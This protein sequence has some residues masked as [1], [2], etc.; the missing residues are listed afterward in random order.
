[1][2]VG[3]LAFLLGICIHVSVVQ[4]GQQTRTELAQSPPCPEEKAQDLFTA[5]RS[6]W[7]WEEKE[8]DSE[9]CYQQTLPSP[10]DTLSSIQF[11]PTSTFRNDVV[12]QSMQAEQSRNDAKLPN[13]RATLVE[14][15][16]AQEVPKCKQSEKGQERAQAKFGERQTSSKRGIWHRDH[17]EGPVG[18]VY[19]TV[20]I[21]QAEAGRDSSRARA[22]Q[23]DG[24]ANSCFREQHHIDDTGGE[25]ETGKFSR[26]RAYGDGT[27][28]KV[29]AGIRPVTDEGERDCRRQSIIAWTH[30]SLEK[31]ESTGANLW[32]QDQGHGSPVATLRQGHT[33]EDKP[34]CQSVSV[35]QSGPD[36]EVQFEDS[37]M[38][39]CEA[40]NQSCIPKSTRSRSAGGTSCGRHPTG[41]A[42]GVPERRDVEERSGS[43]LDLRRRGRGHG[44]AGR[45]CR[46][47]GQGTEETS[48]QSQPITKQ[49][50][51]MSLESEGLM[52]SSASDSE[53]G[54][55]NEQDLNIEDLFQLMQA[56]MS[57][58]WRAPKAWHAKVGPEEGRIEEF[59]PQSQCH[60]GSSS[61]KQFKRK[62]AKAFDFA[63]KSKSR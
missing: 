43:Q 7:S 17:R 18:D 34:P 26:I 37:G 3:R 59:E 46:R 32:I 54:S 6:V 57:A 49:S 45:E 16:D 38:E 42:V 5:G 31:T 14:G 56:D 52:I 51:A 60:G 62:M 10:L 29:S 4:C 63:P 58:M 48:L 8:K 2:S 21:D 35:M 28:R 50:S 41:T 27:S 13:M 24:N 47:N 12:L 9:R 19:A 25:Q 11:F 53:D 55:T 40:G 33:S 15:L 44:S 22:S 20:T 61:G 30:P 39:T 1:M 23:G 36:G